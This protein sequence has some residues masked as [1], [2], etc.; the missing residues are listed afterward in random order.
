MKESEYIDKKKYLWLLSTFV[1]LVATLGVYL[2]KKTHQS[3][4]MVI[5]LFFIY[6]FIP[7]L[8]TIF[9]KDESN[10]PESVVPVLEIEKERQPWQI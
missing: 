9:S 8:D 5:P 3:W 7:L 10:P 6:G 1:P 2:Y 4:V